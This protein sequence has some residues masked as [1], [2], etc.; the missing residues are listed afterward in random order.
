MDG[1]LGADIFISEGDDLVNGGDGDDVALMGAGDDVFVWNPGDDNGTLEGQS[2]FDRMLFNGSNA[3]ENIQLFANGERVIFLRDIAAV[4]MDLDDVEAIDYNA[5]SGSDTVVVSDL[6]E[7]DVDVEVNLNLA[8]TIGG[9]AGVP[10][11]TT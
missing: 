1:G 4:T 11:R 2:G 5:V 8:G 7:T 6:S 10:R 3:A 9:S